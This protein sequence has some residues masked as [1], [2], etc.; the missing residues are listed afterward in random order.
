METVKLNISC[1]RKK[2]DLCCI[3]NLLRLIWNATWLIFLMPTTFLSADTV[4]PSHIN[5]LTSAF[6]C[7]FTETP[8]EVWVGHTSLISCC[9]LG[10][11]SRTLTIL[12]SEE[13]GPLLS[14]QQ[15]HA[16]LMTHF[17]THRICNISSKRHEN[18]S[19]H[20]NH[21]S[22]GCISFA[23]LRLSFSVLLCE[24]KFFPLAARS[25]HFMSANAHYNTPFLCFPEPFGFEGSLFLSDQ[26]PVM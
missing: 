4:E 13:P 23:H 16:L 9:R 1:S 10:W 8:E 19:T 20:G 2:H 7:S 25:L 14:G 12:H 21:T 3:A 11:A 15:S 5:L 26:R 18:D 24:V 17:F 6:W 22:Y